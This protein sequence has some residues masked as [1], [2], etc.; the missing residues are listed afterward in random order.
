MFKCY[1]GILLGNEKLQILEL[2]TREIYFPS[3]FVHVH[4]QCII[5]GTGYVSDMESEVQISF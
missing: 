2:D 3:R 4:V 5:Y 1:S